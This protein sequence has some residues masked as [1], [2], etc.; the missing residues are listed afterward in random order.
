MVV[1]DIAHFKGEADPNRLLAQAVQW[2]GDVTR[3]GVPLADARNA[4]DYANSQLNRI[5]GGSIPALDLAPAIVDTTGLWRAEYG[6]ESMYYD[7][8]HL[9]IAGS[10]RL[11]PLF[12]AL[13]NRLA[14][15]RERHP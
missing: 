5:A 14:A 6:G 2:G 10:L 9:S 4:N 13:F 11:Q 12:E 7:Y 3:I 15:V 8:G 1:R